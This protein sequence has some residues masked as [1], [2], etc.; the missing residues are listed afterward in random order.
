VLLKRIYQVLSEVDDTFRAEQKYSFQKPPR[1]FKKYQ[2][3]KIKVLRKDVCF[4]AHLSY[5]EV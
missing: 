3:A 4:R 5:I 2:G 1:D